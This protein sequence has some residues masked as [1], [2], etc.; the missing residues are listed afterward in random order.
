MVGNGEVGFSGDGG[1]PTSA[2]LNHPMGLLLDN[3]GNLYIADT[4]K[5]E[6]YEPIDQIYTISA[7]VPAGLAI[8]VSGNVYVADSLQHGSFNPSYSVAVSI[9]STLSA[10]RPRLLLLSQSGLNF[11]GVGEGGT[12][13]AQNIGILNIGQGSMNWTAASST[14]SGG[15]WLQVSPSASRCA[16]LPRCL[17]N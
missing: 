5:I 3:T 4:T 17:G 10:P 11:I 15:N 2:A 7:S 1:P 14:L 16:T 9:A 13:L 8:N 12:S 6:S